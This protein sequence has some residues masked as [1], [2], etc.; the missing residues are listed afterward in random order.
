MLLLISTNIRAEI[1]AR[2]EDAEVA[3]YTST[4]LQLIKSPLV[5]RNEAATLSNSRKPSFTADADVDD[6]LEFAKVQL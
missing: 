3:A 6:D 4:T 1:M 2:G 5:E